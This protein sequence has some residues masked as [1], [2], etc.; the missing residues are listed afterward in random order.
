MATTHSDR[1]T[2]L[3]TRAVTSSRGA[4]HTVRHELLP[5]ALY[6]QRRARWWLTRRSPVTLPELWR[7][8]VGATAVLVPGLILALLAPDLPI[9]TP[10]I[11]LMVAV[12]I[13]TYLADWS[14]GLTALFFAALMLDLL[15]ISDRSSFSL[16]RDT[17]EA[18]SFAVTLAAGAVIIWL[19]E[20][21]KQES[22]EA[23]LDAAAARAAAS[24]LAAIES[25]ALQA[26]GN[27]IDLDAALTKILTAMIRTSRAHAGTLWLTNDDE[28]VL[29]REASY[30]LG[31]EDQ[32]PTVLHLGEG[33][34]GQVAL[35][36]RPVMSPNLPADP[37][38][39][40]HH[41]R[42]AGVH[43]VL[44]VPLISDD[45]RLL[46][47]AQIGLLVPHRFS[48]TDIARLQALAH[49]A[50]VWLESARASGQRELLLRRAQEE[51]RRLQM[52]IAAMPEA[53]VIATP[54]DGRVVAFNGA[55]ERLLGSLANESDVPRALTRLRRPDGERPEQEDLP[56]IRALTTGEVATGVELVV[57]GPND[58]E[59][60]VLASAA[61][62]RERD[63]EI[64][65][66]VGVFQDIAPLKE[67]AR[68]KDEFVSVV[69]HEL[70]SPLTPIRGFVQLV[71]RDLEREGNHATHVTW[72]HSIEGHVD[73][74]TRLVDDLLDVSRLRAGRLEIK[75]ERTDL[76]AMAHEIVQSRRS[77]APDHELVIAT[78]PPALIGQ[79]DADRI[80]QVIDNLVSNAIKYSPAGGK[81]TISL[82][83]DSQAKPAMAEIIVSD[84]GGG[85]PPEDRPHIFSAFY[86]SDEAT[87]SRIAGLGLGLF[88]CQQLVAAHGGT[89]SVDEAP[90]GGA[91]FIVRLPVGLSPRDLITP[92]PPVRLTA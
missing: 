54:P 41:L 51:Q 12:A 16:P 85:V 82:T 52:I 33:F 35:E 32:E 43:G 30:G 87:S 45:D 3:A 14:G 24:A 71:A 92:F 26:P 81:V 2:S 88:I 77:A 48:A 15:F 19:I 76:V 44:G 31:H 73:R 65:A 55:A 56:L 34:A 17:T 39:L 72:L 62:L 59:I 25:P 61:P 74:M 42:A 11:V 7:L 50:V 22:T 36:R 80:H 46:G 10:G 1:T 60:P 29:I 90:A 9:T 78:A 28:T 47:V 8:V 89:I 67:A 84:Q 38:F 18:G 13:A 83:E 64:V 79:W 75:P 37:R 21:I 66:V 57:D 49:R 68:V 63:G 86:R 4:A 53:V 91:A 20:R 69:S 5:A 6:R 23:R 70:R 58:S 27:P 40:D